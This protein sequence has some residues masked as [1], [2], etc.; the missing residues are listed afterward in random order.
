MVVQFT[1][2]IYQRDSFAHFVL[3]ALYV[4][5][6]VCISHSVMFDCDSVDCGPPC[7][8]VHGV[9]QAGTLEWVA[10]SFSRDQTHVSCVFCLA[11]RFFTTKPPGKLKN[12]GVGCY[13]LRQGIFP[14]QG[15]NPGLLHCSQILYHL[16]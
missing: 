10:I 6:Y 16:R 2:N 4:C 1:N 12:T 3:L 14:T 15:S 13:F 11:G 9:F 5:M 7:S 8:S